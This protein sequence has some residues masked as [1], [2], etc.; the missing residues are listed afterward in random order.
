MSRNRS[1]TITH[2]CTEHTA[3]HTVAHSTHSTQHT[4]HSIHISPGAVRCAAMEA[5]EAMGKQWCVVWWCARTDFDVAVNTG[6]EQY[7]HITTQSTKHALTVRSFES[8]TTLMTLHC[9]LIC[10]LQFS[11]KQQSIRHL[12]HTPTNQPT[13]HITS[14]H[15]TRSGETKRAEE[16]AQQ[17]I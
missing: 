6:F 7:T 14:H 11:L 12:K 17:S 8:Q 2:H 5:M 10:I 9:H 1:Q 4:A 15:I 3:Q 16:R 13:N